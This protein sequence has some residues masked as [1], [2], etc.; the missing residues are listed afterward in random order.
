[1]ASVIQNWERP[2]RRRTVRHD[3]HVPIDV[4]VLR[5]GIPD[6]LPG[7]VLNLG[8]GGVAALLAGE[9]LPAEPV[10]IEI[11]LPRA[12]TPLRMRAQVKHY[13]KLRSGMQ[14]VGVSA[15]QRAQI[16]GC[17]GAGKTEKHVEPPAEVPATDPV[18]ASTDGNS[19]QPSRPGR[20][21]LLGLILL[22]V[23]VAAL[24]A[25][26]WWGHWNR[27]WQNLEVGLHDR[28][29]PAESILPQAH[30]PAEV[31][32][33]LIIHRVDPDYPAAARSQNLQGI[34]V[35][36]VTVGRDG[37]V[38]DVRARNGP[39]ILAQAAVN[40]LRWWRFQPYFIDRQASVVETTVAVEFKP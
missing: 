31:M 11:F 14:F 23:V 10:A 17:T 9:L 7:R 19:G 16:M 20:K 8:E 4:T 39:D 13:D 28:Q 3:I 25:G 15:E 26:W 38:V 37:S 30:I 1:M 2:S 36:D 29:T 12:S 6:T 35:L 21:K 24:S 32:Q 40:A 27:E 18:T 34:I 33:R 5:S 22:L